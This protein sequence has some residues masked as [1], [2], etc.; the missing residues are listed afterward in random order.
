MLHKEELVKI[1]KETGLPALLASFVTMIP[2]L[3]IAWLVFEPF[4]KSSVSVALADDI[5]TTVQREVAPISG[6]FKV[7]ISANIA[8]LKKDVAQLERLRAADP[9]KWTEQQ[10]NDLVE[11]NLELEA[12]QI[13]LA[14]LK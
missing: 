13:A 10:A 3:G 9:T 5:K 1:T 6:G 4:L 2:I 11:K 7:L 14:L 12:Q 8:K